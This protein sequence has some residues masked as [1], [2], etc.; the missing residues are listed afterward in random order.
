MHN[1]WLFQQ[2]KNMTISFLS[3]LAFK[4]CHSA[5][6]VPLNDKNI[7]FIFADDLGIGDIPGFVDKPTIPLPN[8]D[9]LRKH[10][11][12]FKNFHATPWCAPSRYSVLSGNYQFRGTNPRGNFW[13]RGFS[14]FPDG[15]ETVAQLLQKN[16]YN[17]AIF[18][19]WHLGG[20]YPEKIQESMTNNCTQSNSAACRKNKQEEINKCTQFNRLTCK[21][22]DWTKPFQY[23]PPDV[24]F[25]TS[26]ISIGGIQGPPYAYLT[27]GSL[28]LSQE[29]IVFYDIGEYE[30]PKGISEII[31]AGDGDKT[32]DSSNYNQKI[33]LDNDAFLDRHIRDS[34]TSPFFS[35]LSLGAIHKPITPPYT[36]IDGTPV[37]NTHKHKGH[38]ILYE[39]DLLV[40][41]AVSSLEKRNLL[42]KTLV[43]F[44]SDNGGVSKAN[45]PGANH[46]NGN[47]RGTKGTIWEGGNT[48]PLI[49][50]YGN[51]FPMD[52]SRNQLAGITDIYATIA[53]FAGIQV[54][55]NQAIDSKSLLQSVRDPA[56]VIRE[57]YLV[58]NYRNLPLK[59]EY[60]DEYGQ[61]PVAQSI[62]NIQYKLIYN[63]KYNFIGMFDL[64]NDQSETKE[65]W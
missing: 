21:A 12:S 25:G 64:I 4:F 52:A 29:D 3:L 30:R 34:P 53:E 46:G 13:A 42:D 2:Q 5:N 63:T 17:T 19:K 23:G 24:G 18:G 32:W 59:E 9:K 6:S 56:K 45:T 49:M 15:E 48:V 50:R 41:Y 22:Y 14:A 55:E 37:K 38:D 36:F 54:P 39:L 33:L 16:G 62:Q 31:K 10:G 26:E 20:K 7:V 57:S 35:F 58:F 47:L 61:Q 8:I 60:Y 11:I 51:K 27:N 1:L 28:A 44:L 65:I 40:G 43:I